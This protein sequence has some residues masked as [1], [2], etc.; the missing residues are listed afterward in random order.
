[1]LGA[2]PTRTT[3]PNVGSQIFTHSRNQ[4]LLLLSPHGRGS[5][6]WAKGF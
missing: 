6:L 4:P 2:T 5:T 1:M 3:S